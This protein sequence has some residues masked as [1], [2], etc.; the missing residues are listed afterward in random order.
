MSIAIALW[1]PKFAVEAVV[2]ASHPG[3]VSFVG[4]DAAQRRIHRAFV[5]LRGGAMQLF[6]VL[7]ATLNGVGLEFRRAVHHGRGA[8]DGGQPEQSLCICR[9]TSSREPAPFAHL[10]STYSGPERRGLDG[11]GLDNEIESGSEEQ[12]TY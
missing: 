10:E 7:P 3:F 1:Q 9:F 8:S 5:A 2:V 4:H 11:D 12:G 6:V